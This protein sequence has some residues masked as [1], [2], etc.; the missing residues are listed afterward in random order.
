MR[1]SFVALA[2]AAVAAMAQASP[3]TDVNVVKRDNNQACNTGDLSIRAKGK[4]ECITCT[5]TSTANTAAIMYAS[6]NGPAMHVCATMST[7][8][9]QIYSYNYCKN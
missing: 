9:V 1:F 4:Y 7:A 5:V 2:V 6:D 3:A 8:C